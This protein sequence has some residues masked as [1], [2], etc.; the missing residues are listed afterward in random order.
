MYSVYFYVL[1]AA[2]FSFHPVSKA[3]AHFAWP[4]ARELLARNRVPIADRVDHV[5][6]TCARP[7]TVMTSSGLRVAPL[8]TCTQI[9]PRASPIPSVSHHLVHRFVFAFVLSH[10][11]GSIVLSLTYHPLHTPRTLLYSPARFSP[12]S[13]HYILHLMLV[14]PGHRTASWIESMQSICPFSGTRWIL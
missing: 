9:I 11:I 2:P 4:N 13:Y 14:A 5:L 10:R 8:D 12:S 7:A 3:L 6:V 1:S